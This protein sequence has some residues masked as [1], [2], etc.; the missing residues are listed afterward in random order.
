MRS[1]EL[2]MGYMLFLSLVAAVGGLLFGYD[3]AVISGTIGQVTEQFKLNDWQQGW[4]VGCA[5][6][7]SIVGVSMAGIL[8]DK[9]GAQACH[10]SFRFAVFSLRNLV[11]DSFRLC[12]PCLGKNFRRS[13][14]R[15]CFH[16]FSVVY[17]R[18]CRYT[19]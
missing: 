4:Y 5:L 6:V 9:W 15:Y 13:C 1:L 19:V 12:T 2:N 18:G 11:C 7:G 17:I 8:S 14:N 16:S 3:T 10:D